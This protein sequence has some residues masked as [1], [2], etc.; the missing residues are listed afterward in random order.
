M[1]SR[2]VWAT[3]EKCTLSP[4]IETIFERASNNN[5][6]SYVKRVQGLS[7]I[8]PTFG[9]VLTPSGHPIEDSLSFN[10]PQAPYPFKIGSPS[11]KTLGRSHSKLRSHTYDTVV[12]FRH[13]HEENYYHFLIDV[14]GG[15]ELLDEAC[16]DGSL[17]IVLGGHVART[18]FGRDI[19]KIGGLRSRNWV[20]QDDECIWAENVIFLR[21]YRNSRIRADHLLD[22]MEVPFPSDFDGDRLFLVRPPGGSRSI[23]NTQEVAGVLK[24][25]G[26]REVVTDDL[27]LEEQIRLFQ[28]ARY[29][30][31]AHGAGLTNIIFRRGAPL[32]LLELH[33][34]TWLQRCYGDLCSEYGYFLDR[35][36]CIGG[37]S[38]RW[39]E[40]P[41]W[42]DP[43]L[44]ERRVRRLLAEG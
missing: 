5:S 4:K 29:V 13:H 34:H 1:S 35:L 30:V 7:R 36:P 15:L 6:L 39:G 10:H 32:A 26:F 43:G 14:L 19:L 25:Y 23:S 12:S 17:P 38:E 18:R 27:P 37:A 24:D 20:V 11:P 44:L 42:V 31:G 16:L 41:L 22:L 21:T 2:A 8:E 40:S 9:Y 3:L 28:H 33:A